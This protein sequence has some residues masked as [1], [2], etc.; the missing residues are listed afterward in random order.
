MTFGIPHDIL[1][2]DEDGKLKDGL[3]EAFVEERRAIDAARK[4]AIGDRIDYPNPE[5]V[6]MGR[7][8]PYQEYPGNA[9]LSTIFNARREEYHQ[10][11][12]FEKTVMSYDITKVIHDRGGR[13]I[14]RDET[15]GGWFV[16]AENVAREKI[17]GGFRTRTRRQETQDKGTMEP[18]KKRSKVDPSLFP[19]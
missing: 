13:F 6:L 9:F 10:A 14:Q 16:V 7:G 12:R 4:S 5:D 3:M 17:S 2:L 15:T 11:G 19:Y 8:R 1:P 18:S